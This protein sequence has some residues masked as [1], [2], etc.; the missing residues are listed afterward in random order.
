MFQWTSLDHVGAERI[1]R[2][3]AKQLD[4]ACRSTSSTST[5]STLDQDGSLLISARNTWAV[6]DIRPADR[7]D[8]LAARRASTAASRWAPGTRTAWQHD[9][10]AARRTA[11]SASSTTAPRRRCTA[12]RAAIVVK[13][14]TAAAGRRRSSASSPTR[15]RSLADSQ[16]NMQALANGDWFVGWGQVPDFSEFSADRAA[17]VRRAL[18]RRRPVL[19]GSALRLDRHPGP[20]S[21]VR[22]PGRRRRR[23]D[24]LRELERRHAR[25]A[26]WRVLAGASAHEPDSRRP[27]PRSGFETAIPLPPADGRAVLAV[28]ALDAGG[29]VLGTSVASAQSGLG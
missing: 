14:R 2:A 29:N 28:Q 17:A 13:P 6:Y 16:G 4:G 22:R 18:P 1:V 23:G 11:R 25:V 12:S 10:R 26:R 21:G 19:P 15:R 27:G 5:R 20:P 24:R 9:P 8:R 3:A 7:P